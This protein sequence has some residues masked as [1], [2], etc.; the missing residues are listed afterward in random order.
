MPDFLVGFEKHRVLL[1]FFFRM[2]KVSSIE[3]FV[4]LP[5]NHEPLSYGWTTSHLMRKLCS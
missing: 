4:E 2:E 5:K 1:H 3:G